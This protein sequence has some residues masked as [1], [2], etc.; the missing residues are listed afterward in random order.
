MGMCGEVLPVE[1]VPSM[2]QTETLYN[3]HFHLLLD[4]SFESWKKVNHLAA[5][6]IMSYD[7]HQNSA[8]ILLNYFQRKQRKRD[9]SLLTHAL[10]S[11]RLAR[12]HIP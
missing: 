10:A 5:K 8:F 1:L 6:H 3:K 7:T 4:T 11:S 2:Y 9:F 12:S